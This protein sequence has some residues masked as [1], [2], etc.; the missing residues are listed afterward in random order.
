MLLENKTIF[1]TGAGQGIG[2]STAQAV[3]EEGAHVVVTDI[4]ESVIAETAELVEGTGQRALPLVVD[5]TD[6][7][8]VGGAIKET[9][10][11][12]GR[13]DG[14]VNN[15][16]VIKMDSALDITPED[17]DFQFDVNVKGLFI[18]SQLAAKQMIAQDNGGSIVNIASNCGK[19]G[20][21][22]MAVYN[23]SKAAVISITRSLAAELA[24]NNINVNALCPGG[25]DTPMLLGAA[26]WV[27]ERF[28]GDPHELVSTMVPEQMGR[29]VQPTE[30]G[31]LVA[32]LLSDHAAPIRGQSISA[33]GGDTPY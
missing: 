7:K 22:N 6:A 17:W 18:C 31:H 21:P 11:T 28:G 20:Y 12:F 32:F 8:A 14:W 25:V 2:R 29:H 33:D 27:T 19:A 5:V 24:G 26:K 9:V 4:H 16:G 23:A 1:V 30:I 15:A 10:E 3:A 13:L